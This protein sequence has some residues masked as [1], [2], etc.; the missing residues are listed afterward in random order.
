M[1]Y[2]KMPDE[3]PE[4]TMT[5]DDTSSDDDAMSD[6]DDSDVEREKKIKSLQDKVMYISYHQP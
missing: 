5:D 6:A 4:S 2:A 3:P 1:R